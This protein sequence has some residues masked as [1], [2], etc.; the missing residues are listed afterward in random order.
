MVNLNQQD[1]PLVNALKAL[2]QQP[3]TPFYAPG[4]KRGQGISP[5]FKQWLGPNLFQADLPG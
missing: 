5:S 3:D 2:A 4:H 1:L